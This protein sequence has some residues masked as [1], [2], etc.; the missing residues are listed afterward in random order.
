M[1][2]DHESHHSARV[3]K[4]QASLQRE[5]SSIKELFKRQEAININRRK[6]NDASKV[7]PLSEIAHGRS[8]ELSLE[9][10]YG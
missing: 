3:G 10:S 4:C 6:H 5:A 2:L 9:R 8:T 7:V 1:D